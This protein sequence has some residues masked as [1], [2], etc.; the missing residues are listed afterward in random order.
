MLQKRKSKK[1]G[2]ESW[3]HWFEHRWGKMTKN[4]GGFKKLRGLL[5]DSQQ[6]KREPPPYDGS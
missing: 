1:F 6:R 4:A 2:E 3:T 5:A